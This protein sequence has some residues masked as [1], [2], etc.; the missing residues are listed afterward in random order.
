MWCT[1]IERAIVARMLARSESA[2]DAKRACSTVWPNAP[3]S[4]AASFKPVSAQKS[5]QYECI[6]LAE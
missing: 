6:G 1:F 2:C 3:A 5:S 4:K